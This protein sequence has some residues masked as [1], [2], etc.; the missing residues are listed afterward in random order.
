MGAYPQVPGQIIQVLMHNASI[1][2]TNFFKGT[3]TVTNETLPELTPIT[4]K[5]PCPRS[6]RYCQNGSF[7]GLR[8]I[9]ADDNL[10]NE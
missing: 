6:G 2:L 4:I 5:K 8:Y 9:L 1:F 7:T 10:C 3:E